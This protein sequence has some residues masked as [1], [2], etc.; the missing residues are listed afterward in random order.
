MNTIRHFYFVATVA[1]TSFWGM[2]AEG[3]VLVLGNS[4]NIN[5]QQTVTSGSNFT[6]GSG[7]TS[8]SSVYSNF[9]S[10][11]TLVLRPTFDYPFILQRT[12]STSFT[13]TGTSVN[14]TIPTGGS[15]L[16]GSTLNFIG[17]SLLMGNTLA[18]SGSNSST[19]SGLLN[20][21]NTNTMLGGTMTLSGNTLSAA[22]FSN[23]IVT[24]PEPTKSVLFLL[25]CFGAFLRR[26]RQV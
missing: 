14:P 3:S 24:A 22:Q 17:G 26:N 7:G 15:P 18:I 25:G 8:S 10:S 21:S 23:L 6:V 5:N 16:G 13:K 12:G 9:S 20:T 19:V 2:S 11:G 1:L 4:G